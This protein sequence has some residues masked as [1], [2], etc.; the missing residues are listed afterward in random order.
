[1]LNPHER[2]RRAAPRAP[3]RHP[4]DQ[5][6]SGTVHYAGGV[7]L[8]RSM[9]PGWLSNSYLVGDHPGGSAVLI[10]AGGPPEPIVAAID[11]HRLNVTQI[12]VTHHH[13]DH[14]AHLEAMRERYPNAPV[15]AHA[16][17][18]P[19][20]PGGADGTLDQ[21]DV[22]EGGDLRIE[23]LHTPGHTD[24]M[25]SF[26]VDGAECFTG[27]TLFAGSVGGVRGA[28][29]TSFEDLRGSIMDRLL[30]LS[31]SCVINPGHIGHTTVA[32]E[33][34]T[35][36]FVRLWRGLDSEGSEPC[37]ALGE[38]ATL[39][40]WGDDYDGGYKAWVRWP[41]GRDDIV[42]GSRVERG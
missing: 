8:E 33:W 42:P 41:D 7:I 14:V 37:K 9:E 22:V 5:D 28:T 23:A 19:R 32:R 13:G 40:L 29:A 26:V 3:S 4:H 11:R 30:T 27:D 10:D 25:L 34:E 12:L 38:P 36:P 20:L 31:P 6:T 35:N 15:L 18:A 1:M 17:E 24:G 16:L 21:G 39:I 2:R